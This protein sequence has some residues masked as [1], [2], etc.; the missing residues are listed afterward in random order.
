MQE[1]KPVAWHTEDEKDDKSATTY[2]EDVAE[3][4]RKKEWPV[5]PMFYALPDTHRIVTVELLETMRAEFCRAAEDVSDWG[6][7][8][9]AYFQ[10]KHD[11]KS[12]IAN[13]SLQAKKVQAIID[14]ENTE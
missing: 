5:T 9:S 12:C 8:A 11:L 10:N 7:Y 3:N 6:D 14:K 2:D 1:L 4:W 13:Y